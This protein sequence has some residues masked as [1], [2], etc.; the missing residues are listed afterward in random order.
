MENKKF[1]FEPEDGTRDYVNSLNLK[2][3][4]GMKILPN[5]F[6]VANYGV[7][8]FYEKETNAYFLK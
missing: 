4:D 5:N 7:P 3:F 2:T 1:N 6:N 8:I